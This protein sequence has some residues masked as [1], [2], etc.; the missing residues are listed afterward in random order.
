MGTKEEPNTVKSRGNSPRKYWAFLLSSII[1]ITLIIVVSVP[2][3]QDARAYL[4]SPRFGAPT[5]LDPYLSAEENIEEDNTLQIIVGIDP[6]ERSIPQEWISKENW[7][8]GL[9][10]SYL[11]NATIQSRNIREIKKISNPFTAEGMQDSSSL[12]KNAVEITI[13]TGE[14]ISPGLY[15]LHVAYNS[16][17]ANH[18]GI[19]EAGEYLGGAGSGTGSASFTL[20]EVNCVYISSEIDTFA[21]EAQEPG[22]IPFS[23]IHISDI[24]VMLDGNSDIPLNKYRLESLM[25][26]ISIW[27]PDILVASG[28]LTNSPHEYPEEYTIIYELLKDLGVPLFSGNGNHDHKNLGLYPYYF[29]PIQQANQWGGTRLIN[30]NSVLPPDGKSLEWAIS[31]IKEGGEQ[32]EATFFVAHYPI[33]DILDREMQTSVGSILDAMV[34]YDAAGVLNGHNHY[35]LVFD[36]KEAVGTYYTSTSMLDACHIPQ[37]VGNSAPEIEDPKIFLV[38]SAAKDARTGLIESGVWED[39]TP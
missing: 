28:D 3:V 19:V 27:A 14:D 15:N 25:Q 16:P 17:L 36:M 5:R 13:E 21:T 34:K 29:G 10:T 23:L 2:I 1:S 22:K 8:I 30:I 11:E 37:I 33:M 12:A 39:Y 38:S 24:H 26:A 9:S 31:N 6:T 32:G 35:N 18:A 4:A 7:D 20:S